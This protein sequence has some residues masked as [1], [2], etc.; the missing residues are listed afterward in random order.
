M[1]QTLEE[2][3]ATENPPPPPQLWTDITDMVKAYAASSPRSLQRELGPSEIGHPCMRKM[4]Y[5]IMGV[6]RCNPEYDPLPSIIGTATHSWMEKAAAADNERLGRQR[7]LTETKVDVAA[8]LF[9]HCDLFDCDTG[10]VIDYKF[11]GY[12][13]F[14]NYVKDPGPEY[15]HQIHLYGKGFANAGY[16]VRT[17]AIAFFPR[18]GTL[19]KMNLFHEDY[20]PALADEVLVRRERVIGLLD[21]LDVERNPERYQWIPATP[22]KCV[23]CPWWKPEPQ[24][25]LQCSGEAA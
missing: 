25:P 13:S 14:M 24:S 23:W 7:W 3:F 17:V 9:G 10:T 11:P 2:F 22:Y 19:S 16:D 15:R 4:A 18:A 12:T 21:D 8:G 20:N 6:P 1:T 5:G